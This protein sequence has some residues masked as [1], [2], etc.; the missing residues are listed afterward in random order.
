MGMSE[1]EGESYT[2]SLPLFTYYIS[3]LQHALLIE[4]YFY[5]R[6]LFCFFSDEEWPI[7]EGVMLHLCTVCV[8]PAEDCF[9]LSI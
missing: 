9:R 5:T 3:L 1:N 8:M 2:S 4:S 7:T 6:A